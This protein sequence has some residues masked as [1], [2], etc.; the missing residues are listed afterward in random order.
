M[1]QYELLPDAVGQ[2]VR[3]KKNICLFPGRAATDFWRIG[4]IFFGK[5]FFFSKIFLKAN[6]SY[7]TQSIYSNGVSS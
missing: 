4:K 7:L 3:P 5:I 2:G 6:T 1:L